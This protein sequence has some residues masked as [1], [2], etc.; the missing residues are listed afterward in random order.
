MQNRCVVAA[1]GL[2]VLALAGCSQQ[3][4]DSVRATARTHDQHLDGSLISAYSDVASLARDSTAVVIAK[5]IGARQESADAAGESGVMAAVT[6]VSITKVLKGGINGDTT[7]DVR[8]LP[9]DGTGMDLQKTYLLF[10]TPFTFSSSPPNGEW[11]VTGAVGY[12]AAAGTQ[13]TL[14]PGPDTGLPRTLS[15]QSVVSEL[16]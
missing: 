10:L 5:A 3:G 15:L 11:V 12:Y 7:I 16:H 14:A 1:V 8:Q 4:S 6:H 9:V 13:F 2:T